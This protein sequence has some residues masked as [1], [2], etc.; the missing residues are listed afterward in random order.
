M[1]YDYDII[2]LFEIFD[3]FVNGSSKY[4]VMANA[5]IGEV[6]ITVI[7]PIKG[8]QKGSELNNNLIIQNLVKCI[9]GT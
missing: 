8:S 2:Y 6:V 1:V 7:A 5:T 3:I 9:Y 4:F